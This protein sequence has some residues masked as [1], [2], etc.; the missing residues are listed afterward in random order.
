MPITPDPTAVHRE[1]AEHWFVSRGL[2]YFVDDTRTAVRQ[3]LSRRRL[4]G[5]A[6]VAAAVAAATAVGTAWWWQD[7][8]NSVLTAVVAAGIPLVGYAFRSLHAGSVARWAI[9]RTFSSLGLLI[10]LV[11]KALPLLLLFVTFL[12][13][14]T[15]VWQVASSLDDGVLWVAVLLFAAV[16]V[17]FLLVRLPEELDQVDDVMT[18]ELLVA[19]CAGTPLDT[20]AVRCAAEVDDRTLL[21]RAQVTGLAKANLVVALLISQALQVLLLSLAMFTF[22]LVFGAVA[23]NDDVITSWLGHPST[24]FVDWFPVLTHELVRVAT[25]LAAFSGL[26]FTVYAVSDETYR[27]QFFGSLMKQLHRAVGVRTVYRCLA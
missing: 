26:Y 15:E 4:L 25:F 24:P 9:G 21:E 20:E 2:P 11:T 23:I 13:I 19:A 27:S 12:F 10:P 6:A 16:A 18:G 17:A 14:N 7:A 3:R 8:S 22:F 5:L 1:A